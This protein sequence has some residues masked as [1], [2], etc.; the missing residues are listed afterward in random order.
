MT[1]KNDVYYLGKGWAIWTDGYYLFRSGQIQY[2]G[3]TE[4]PRK[5]YITHKRSIDLMTFIER[6]EFSYAAIANLFLLA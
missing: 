4:P 3:K 5:C 1:Q 2:V 6:Y